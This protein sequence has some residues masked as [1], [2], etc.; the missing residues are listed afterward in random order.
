MPP[1][2]V[3]MGRGCVGEGGE[4]VPECGAGSAPFRSVVAAKELDDIEGLEAE[5][6]E[7]K[8]GRLKGSFGRGDGEEP[9]GR[10]L[11][12]EVVAEAMDERSGTDDEPPTSGGGVEANDLHEEV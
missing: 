9:V 3:T 10:E 12:V 7:P 11:K 1:S 6:R 2:L 5:G 8:V 4:A